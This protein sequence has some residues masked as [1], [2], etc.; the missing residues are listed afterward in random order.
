MNKLSK[1]LLIC[2]AV[3]GAGVACAVWT[4]NAL[5]SFIKVGFLWIAWYM[6]YNF[7]VFNTQ[8]FF[9]LSVVTLFATFCVLFA[10]TIKITREE[11]S[12]YLRG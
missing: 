10:S 6:M 1:S 8:Q 7:H 4:L 3:I 11:K 9:W 12:E 2:C 5:K